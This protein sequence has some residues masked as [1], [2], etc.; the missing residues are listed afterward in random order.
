MQ[1]YN[2]WRT[3]RRQHHNRRITNIN[4]SRAVEGKKKTDERSV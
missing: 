3:I 2:Q 4:R 1:E